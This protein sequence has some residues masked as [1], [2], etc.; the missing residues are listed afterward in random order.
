[1]KIV[2]LTP[3]AIVFF[4]GDQQVLTVQPSGQLARCQEV[5]V[6]VGATEVEGASI[7]LIRK[8]FGELQGLPDPEPETIYLVSALAAQPAWKLGRGDVYTV[9]DPVRDDQNRVVGCR[10]LCGNPGS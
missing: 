9:G 7:P 2:N 8:T 3:H 5:P 4:A 6:H 10:S 1:M